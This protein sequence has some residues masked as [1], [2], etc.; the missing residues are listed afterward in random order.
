M[1]TAVI[2]KKIEAIRLA[3]SG[4]GSDLNAKTE[5]LGDL[6]II[7]ISHLSTFNK[8]GRTLNSRKA[9]VIHHT[10]GRG[11]AKG[12]V[13]VLNNRGLGVQW[14]IDREGKI[15][16]T[17]PARSIGGQILNSTAY[18]RRYSGLEGLNNRNTEGVEVIAKDDAD[19]LSIQVEAAKKLAR[20]LGY[21]PW[22][23]VPHGEVNR[24]HKQATEG[25]TICRAI[26]PDCYTDKMWM[27]TFVKA[28]PSVVSRNSNLA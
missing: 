13:Q 3:F 6:D 22:Q 19:I 12:V 17:L 21:A 16:R 4:V 5:K 27:D 7:D 18:V 28:N 2:N 25:E 14:V 20:A 26:C 15:W 24:G 10:A 8:A 9:F 11:T 23:V 1:D